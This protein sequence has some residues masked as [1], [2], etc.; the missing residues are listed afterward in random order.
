VA[1][2]P[3]SDHLLDERHAIQQLALVVANVATIATDFPH[4]D[5]AA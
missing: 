1:Q 4:L 3:S 2:R 5:L